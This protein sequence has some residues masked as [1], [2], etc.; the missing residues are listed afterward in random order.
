MVR[1]L[2]LFLVAAPV[3]ALDAAQAQ[4]AGGI[5]V[6]PVMIAMSAEHNIASLRVRNGRDRPVAFEVDVYAWRQEGGRDVLT[7]TNDLVVAP[8]VFEVRAESEQ[9]VR[10]G[11]L[12]ANA[13]TERAFRIILRELPSQRQGGAVL[14]FT[15]ELSLPVFIAPIDARGQ[16][17]A[18]AEERSWGPTLIL[19][20]TGRTHVRVAALESAETGPVQAPRY[21]LAGVSVE[22]PLPRSAR[23]IR[24]VSAD[25]GGAEIERIVYVGRP[26]QR[27]DL[28]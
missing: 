23:T 15:L 26:P 27:A 25:I 17:E 19:A 10:L 8:G 4:Q 5:Q 18:R 21:L 6:A 7:P 24:L 1:A 20:N 28:R 22:I 3:M 14:G 13:N 16:V 9:V 11:V 2:F 12:A